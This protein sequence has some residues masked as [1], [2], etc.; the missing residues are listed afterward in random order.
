MVGG[1]RERKG[2]KKESR[3]ND[4]KRPKPFQAESKRLAEKREGLGVVTG[5]VLLL[6]S[7][8]WMGSR[9]LA[10]R[11]FKCPKCLETWAGKFLSYGGPNE[12][13]ILVDSGVRAFLQFWRRKIFWRMTPPFHVWVVWTSQ[14]PVP[15]RAF[16]VISKED[17][18]EDLYKTSAVVTTI[19]TLET[20][21]AVEDFLRFNTVNADKGYGA[22]KL[23]ASGSVLVV[24]P[25]I[26]V[27]HTDSKLTG[28]RV[29]IT[30]GWVIL[31]IKGTIVKADSMQ[32]PAQG[33]DH[34]EKRVRDTAVRMLEG[35]L[36]VPGELISA[37]EALLLSQYGGNENLM[38]AARVERE[39]D[40]AHCIRTSERK[41]K[42]I[43]PRYHSQAVLPEPEILE[44]SG[45]QEYNPYEAY[46]AYVQFGFVSRCTG[47][48]VWGLVRRPTTTILA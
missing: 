22:G 21:R 25:P 32:E 1:E 28:S 3:F 10:G 15:I 11:L 26:E 23:P 40:G 6:S 9:K 34:V 33:W 17:R 16:E 29:T 13:A 20:T 24:V 44:D 12:N 4:R 36:D 5:I 41:T 19:K 38:Y 7:V 30:Y 31:T 43:V 2:K 18:L 47:S 35:E 46:K 27:V 8:F 42:A 37:S 14:S 48:M 39:E 45:A